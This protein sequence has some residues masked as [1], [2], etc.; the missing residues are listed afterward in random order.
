MSTRI[1]LKSGTT[2][3]DVP[4][5]QDDKVGMLPHLWLYNID[6][7]DLKEVDLHKIKQFIYLTIEQTFW[8]NSS[9]YNFIPGIYK[10]AD[11][12]VSISP[13]VISNRGS[14]KHGFNDYAQKVFGRFNSVPVAISF[15]EALTEGRILPTR[16]L[17][18]ELT[19]TEQNYAMQAVASVTAMAK[20]DELEGMLFQQ[21]NHLKYLG[22][23]IQD[24]VLT[25]KTN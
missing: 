5:V 9:G 24:H 20:I 18:R 10:G 8:K 12:E 1:Y 7:K 17:C 11:F 2:E 19:V 14:D 3:Q 13:S 25:P 16:P 22:Q 4:G 21:A 6:F 23:L 15:W